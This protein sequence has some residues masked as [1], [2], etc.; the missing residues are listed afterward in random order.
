MFRRYKALKESEGEFVG[1]ER[2]DMYKKQIRLMGFIIRRAKFVRLSNQL[3]F[4][5]AVSEFYTAYGKVLKYL[6]ID[7]ARGRLLEE[8]PI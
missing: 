5:Q 2:V 3:A 1:L 8:T 7:Q 4:V 6:K